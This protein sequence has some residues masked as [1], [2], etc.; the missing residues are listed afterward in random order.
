LT[1]IAGSPEKHDFAHIMK[2]SGELHPIWVTSTS[3][4]FGSLKEVQLVGKIKVG[5]GSVDVVFE[6]GKGFFN[7]HEAS[8]GAILKA[9]FLFHFLVE[10]NS[11]IHSHVSVVL[12]DTSRCFIDTIIAK[13]VIG[14]VI[15]LD[16]VKRIRHVW[17]NA[18]FVIHCSDG[19]I[20]RDLNQ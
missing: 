10:I 17:S 4:A 2:Q 19:M 13:G 11:V 18:H 20:L 14:L 7:R 5:I 9:V 15:C 6:L 3:N 1:I 8:I 12:H 16:L